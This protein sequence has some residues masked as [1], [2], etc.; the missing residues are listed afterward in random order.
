MN[1]VQKPWNDNS[2]RAIIGRLLGSAEPSSI[3][4]E[5]FL[6]KS[7]PSGIRADF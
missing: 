2:V 1:F 3:E 5:W 7:R 4:M 6:A